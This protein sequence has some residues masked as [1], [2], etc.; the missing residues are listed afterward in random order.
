MDLK[1]NLLTLSQVDL[2]TSQLSPSELKEIELSNLKALLNRAEF[3]IKH[4]EDAIHYFKEQIAEL[5]R[6]L[7][8]KSSEGYLA[9]DEQSCFNEPEFE[10]QESV[11][12]EESQEISV[13]QS[14]D[15]ITVE[16]YQK[17]RGH[18]KP[19]PD[20]LPREKVVLTLPEEE[21]VTVTGESLKIIGYEV[22]E[23]LYFQPAKIKVLAI[24]RAKYGMDS[25]DYV[26][27]TPAEPSLVPIKRSLR[28]YF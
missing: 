7:F 10:A 18:R 5:T 2:L 23:K 3:K 16:A 6:K 24:Y 17:K 9:N 4:Q 12:E 11:T 13:N 20:Y 8:G 26:K 21:L 22:S 1:L 19:L 28:I 14:S 15:P 27:T 25:G